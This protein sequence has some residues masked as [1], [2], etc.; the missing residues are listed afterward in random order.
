MAWALRGVDLRIDAGERVL[1]LGASGA[2]KSTLLLALAGLLDQT[3]GDQEGEL[4]VEGR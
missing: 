4:H 2:G 1:L 3:S